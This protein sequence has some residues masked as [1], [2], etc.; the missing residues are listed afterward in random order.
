M[1][2]ATIRSSKDH[3]GR[4]PDGKKGKAV[5]AYKNRKLQWIIFLLSLNLVAN[6][7]IL[8]KLF[9]VLETWLLKIL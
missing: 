4:G 7:L 9:G 6:V 8:L 2:R 3:A 1:A 5:K